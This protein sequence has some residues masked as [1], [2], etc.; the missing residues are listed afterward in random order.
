M[1]VYV[2]VK[3][4][5]VQVYSEKGLQEYHFD[6]I[7]YLADDLGNAKCQYVTNIM[8]AD[9]GAVIETVKACAPNNAVSSSLDSLDAD[10]RFVHSTIAGVLQIPVGEGKVISF[11]G[12]GDCKVLDEDLYNLIK[13]SFN[14]RQMLKQGKLEIITEQ[15]MRKYV[16]KSNRE[17]AKTKRRFAQKDQ[18]MKSLIIGDGTPGS[19]ERLA[20]G[21][22]DGDDG[23]DIMDISGDDEAGPITEEALRSG[24]VDPSMADL[25]LL[26]DE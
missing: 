6:E 2:D 10:V 14:V 24:S 20:E 5:K 11:N 21:M 13:N 4:Q 18:Q 1:L 22:F 9:I 17:R 12:P 16:R 8:N 3:T 7:E 23:P 26:D 19:A 25:E 15:E